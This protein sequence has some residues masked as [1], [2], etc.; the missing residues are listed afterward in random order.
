VPEAAVVV[1][2]DRVAAV[3]M[4]ETLGA[5]TVILDDGF[6]HRRLS[7]T[8]DVVLLDA[9][10][11]LGN[12]RFLPAGPLRDLPARLSDAGL[13]LLTRS[14]EAGEAAVART[15]AR[16]SLATGA[17]LARFDHRVAGFERVG[18]PAGAAMR[19]AI[20]VPA[21]DLK[22]PYAFAGIAD[23]GRFF[24]SL[25]A[26]GVHPVGMR[27]FRDHSRFG[28]DEIAELERDAREAGAE[29][30]LTTEKD[31]VRLRALGLPLY[32]AVIDFTPVSPADEAVVGALLGQ[33]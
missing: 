8:L 6:Q 25:A 23:P 20:D 16:L 21:L 32:V 30:L 24:T 17:P 14:G 2:P 1:H 33:L 10:S 18:G 28:A 9:A 19:L 12:G 31:A 3:R 26:A 11:P 7:R 29:S 4:A 15:A 5:D 13:V 27:G 22:R